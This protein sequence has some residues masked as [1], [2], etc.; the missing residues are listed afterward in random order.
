MIFSVKN[1]VIWIVPKSPCRFSARQHQ[2][3]I[4]IHTHICYPP[5]KKKNWAGIKESGGERAISSHRTEE[6]GWWWEGVKGGIGQDENG[7]W[8]SSKSKQG[9]GE[10]KPSGSAFSLW[11]ACFRGQQKISWH[12]ARKGD[13]LLLISAEWMESCRN[14]M[15]SWVPGAASSWTA[16]VP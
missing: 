16:A 12:L 2:L 9:R 11:T 14:I 13:P 1:D 15:Y 6:R 10:N 8:G 5:P 3:N 4:R 7:H